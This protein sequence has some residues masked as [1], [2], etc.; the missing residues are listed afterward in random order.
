M[1]PEPNRKHQGDEC[2]GKAVAL[3]AQQKS[4]VSSLALVDNVV[5]GVSG[6]IAGRVLA[7]HLFRTN[8]K[9]DA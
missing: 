4:Y 5:N 7:H 2:D 9:G 6:A 3:T 1:L 8:Q